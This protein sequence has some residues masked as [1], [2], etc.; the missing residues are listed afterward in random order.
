MK[1][2]SS[3]TFIA[4]ASLLAVGSPA[5]AKP[6]IQNGK[7]ACTAEAKKATPSPKSV[8]VD[9]Q[10]TRVTSDAYIFTLRIKNEDASKATAICTFNV[11]DS[12][13]TLAAGE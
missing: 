4:I 6:S 13:V 2:A 10:A 5:L 7:S 12:G 11:Q 1:R 8:R 9:D 3:L